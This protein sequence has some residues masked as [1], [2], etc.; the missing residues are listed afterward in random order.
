[1]AASFRKEKRKVMAKN[2][3]NGKTGEA[4]TA[5]LNMKACLKGEKKKNPKAPMPTLFKTCSK[6]VKKTEAEE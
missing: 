6:L 1:M 3:K 2:G 5:Y 4:G